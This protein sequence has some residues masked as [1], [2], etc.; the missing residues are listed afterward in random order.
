MSLKKITINYN[1]KEYDLDDLIKKADAFDQAY[2]IV[3]K[4]SK[5]MTDPYLERIQDA[6]RSELIHPDHDRYTECP[7]CD[8]Q[9]HA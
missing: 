6:I 9:E 8:Q 3:P 2:Y 7:I 4:G 1:G 5:L